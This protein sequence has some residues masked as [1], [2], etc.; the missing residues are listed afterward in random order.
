MRPPSRRLAPGTG[1]TTP[2]P[3]GRRGAAPGDQGGTT[4]N[5]PSPPPLPPPP[6]PP[7]PPSPW[8]AGGWP[9]RGRPRTPPGGA[10]HAGEGRH[11]RGERSR[12]A[13]A[14]GRPLAQSRITRCRPAALRR[15]RGPQRN[16]GTQ[17]CADE[18]ARLGAHLGKAGEQTVARRP[19]PPRHADPPAANRAAPGAHDRPATPAEPVYPWGVRRRRRGTGT[20]ATGQPPGQVSGE[21]RRGPP[22]PLPPTPPPRP[23]G[24]GGAGPPPHPRPRGRPRSPGRDRDARGGTQL[25]PHAARPR[26]PHCLLPRGSQQAG[27]PAP[28]RKKDARA[29]PGGGT[30]QRTGAVWEPRPP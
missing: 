20:G 3:R 14:P 12:A 7:P 13:S 6:L 22:S 23:A 25:D 11:S 24:H 4:G 19:L 2:S 28:A 9:G 21:Q 26:A 15:R 29:T 5:P 16:G 8:A 10:L 1:T 30:R 17:E 27:E 18:A